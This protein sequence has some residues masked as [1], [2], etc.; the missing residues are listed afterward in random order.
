MHDGMSKLAS[1][2]LITLSVLVL[3][4]FGIMGQPPAGQGPRLVIFPPWRDG[5]ALVAGAGGY[6]VGPDVAAM[7][8]LAMAADDA[9]FDR[10]LKAAGAWAVVDGTAIA[11]LCGIPMTSVP[12]GSTA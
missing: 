4:V 1:A 6:P 5:L 2:I 7:G 8:L 11:R 10:R 3:P 9:A 12:D